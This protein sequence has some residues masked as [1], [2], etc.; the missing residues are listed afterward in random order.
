MKKITPTS[1][2]LQRFHNNAQL[3]IFE[4]YIAN[5]DAYSLYS[6]GVNYALTY[7]EK[8]F[9]NLCLYGDDAQFIDEVL[10]LLYGNVKLCGVS[11]WTKNYLATKYDFLW[12]TDCFLCVWNGK[13]LPYVC[14]QQL[15]KV[16]LQCAQQV[17]D[18]T[19]YHADLKEIRDSIAKRPSSALFVQGK[20]VCWCLL[21]LENSLGMLYTLPEHRRKGYALEVMTHLCNQVIAQGNV[22]FAY[23]VQD[24]VAS[25]NLASKYNLQKVCDAYYFEIV[26]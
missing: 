13:P 23:I 8:D 6:D 17:S 2:L 21:H 1:D 9:V 18:G 11:Q 14:T 25:L 16:P 5:T 10:S 24:N 20:P 12:Q 26:R 15:D 4:G 19:F 22:P 7:P 3:L